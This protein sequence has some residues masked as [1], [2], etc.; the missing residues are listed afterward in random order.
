MSVEKNKRIR[1]VESMEENVSTKQ[2]A[3]QI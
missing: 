1:K 2:A 3:R